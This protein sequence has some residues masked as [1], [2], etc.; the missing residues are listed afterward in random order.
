M[1]RYSQW[2][3]LCG[4]RPLQVGL[5]SGSTETSRASATTA[6]VGA[7]SPV[8]PSL[9]GLAAGTGYDPS[10]QVPTEMCRGVFKKKKQEKFTVRMDSYSFLCGL[11]PEIGFH[12][13][14]GSRS[15]GFR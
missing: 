10:R 11:I 1:I 6:G 15:G 2:S 8:P 12:S 13:G 3:R 4:F 7:P 5:D 14:G 9:L